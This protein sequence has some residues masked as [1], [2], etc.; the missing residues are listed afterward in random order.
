MEGG[1]TAAGMGEGMPRAWA[2]EAPGPVLRVENDKHRFLDHGFVSVGLEWL[3]LCCGVTALVGLYAMLLWDIAA[4][5]GH[6]SLSL[7]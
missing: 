3:V 2:G 1:L 4:S 7:P 6:S 5:E